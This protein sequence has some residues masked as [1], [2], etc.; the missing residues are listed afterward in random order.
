MLLM[1][2]KAAQPTAERWRSPG[3]PVQ[4]DNQWLPVVP[5]GSP[6]PSLWSVSWGAR[7]WVQ[8]STSMAALV[9]AELPAGPRVTP[10]QQ[11]PGGKAE[12]CHGSLGCW[13]AMGS[14]C[15]EQVDSDYSLGPEPEGIC[16]LCRC[17]QT[18][19]AVRTECVY[20]LETGGKQPA[21][22]EISEYDGKSP[23]HSYRD[24]ISWIYKRPIAFA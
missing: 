7:S 14:S 10:H 15:S 13:G 2:A 3:R 1:K 23:S 4:Q 17:S 16:V 8:D 6:V 19:H 9:W 12:L 24:V 22:S 21:V 20:G 11:S 5:S 18:V